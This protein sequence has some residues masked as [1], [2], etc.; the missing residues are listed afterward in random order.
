[1]GGLKDDIASEILIFKSK[2]LL[3]AI[4]LPRIEMR[5]WIDNNKKIRQINHKQIRQPCQNRVSIQPTHLD[6]RVKQKKIGSTKKN[7]WEET[8][9]QRGYASIAMRSSH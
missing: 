7:S 3:E 2:T 8:Q 4:E 9:R 1:M 5:V 6:Q